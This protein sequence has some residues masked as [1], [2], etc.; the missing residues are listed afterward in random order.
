M[1]VP[2]FLI[3][4]GSFI[5]LL[6]FWKANAYYLNSYI[7]SWSQNTYH[8][9]FPLLKR[10][11]QISQYT[12]MR[13]LMQNV[14]WHAQLLI[15]GHPP[16]VNVT[17]TD[18]IDGDKL[19]IRLPERVNFS[20]RFDDIYW[21]IS[22]NWKWLAIGWWLGSHVLFPWSHVNTWY[23]SRRQESQPLN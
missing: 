20:I 16:Y 17:S 22:K 21:A 13:H 4:I 9:V 10:L 19:I 1:V 7:A 3:T 2:T 8:K 14:Y 5:D 18:R 15:V 6:S 12:M 23:A 11:P